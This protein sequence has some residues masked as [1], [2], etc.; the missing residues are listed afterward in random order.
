MKRLFYS[1]IRSERLD[2]NYCQVQSWII[3]CMF[4]SPN[5][6]LRSMECQLR[7]QLCMLKMKKGLF[8]SSTQFGSWFLKEISQGACFFTVVATC[9]HQKSQR[10]TQ[11]MFSALKLHLHVDWWFLL[12]WACIYLQEA[13]VSKHFWNKIMQFLWAVVT[14]LL[15]KC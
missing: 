3:S 11:K 9:K 13:G 8:H 10:G 5:I 7:K 12:I 4:Q 2:T 15:K 6:L 1:V 14:D